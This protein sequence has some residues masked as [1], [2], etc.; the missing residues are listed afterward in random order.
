MAVCVNGHI[1]TDTE[2]LDTRGIFT[3]SKNTETL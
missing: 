1:V 3:I 2:N